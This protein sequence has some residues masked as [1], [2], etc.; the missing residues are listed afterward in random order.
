MKHIDLSTIAALKDLK[1]D[2]MMAKFHLKYMDLFMNMCRF[3]NDLCMM[4][5]SWN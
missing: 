2:M 5:Q 3:W 4:F 1:I